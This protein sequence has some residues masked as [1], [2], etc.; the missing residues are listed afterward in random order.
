[1]HGGGGERGAA[2][3]R[4]PGEATREHLLH[5]LGDA[6]LVGCERRRPAAAALHDGPRLDQVPEHLLDEERVAVRVLVDGPDERRRRRVPGVRRDQRADVARAQALEGHPLDQPVAAQVGQQL[7]ERMRRAD[8]RVAERAEDQQR[9]VARCA[10]DVPEQVE[11]AAVGPVQVV[12]HERERGAAGDV[13]QQRRDRLEEQVALQLGIPRAGRGRRRQLGDHPRELPGAGH[14]G[15]PLPVEPGAAQRLHERLV[16]DQHLLLA[17]GVEHGA[18]GLGEVGEL[19]RE[20]RLADARIAGEH[21]HAAAPAARLRPRVAQQPELAIAGHE[22]GAL[23][24]REPAG[25]RDRR[26]LPC[27]L[28]PRALAGEQPLVQRLELRRGRRAELVAQQ[29]PEIVVDPQRLRDVAGARERLHQE[30]VAGLAERRAGDEVAPGPLGVA[31]LGRPEAERRAGDPL[32]RLELEL[33]RLQPAGSPP[34]RRRRPA[35]SRGAGGGARPRRA[36]AWGPTARRARR[37]ARRRGPPRR[38]P[39]RSRPARGAAGAVARAPRA[40][41][42]RA[43]DAGGRGSAAAPP[44][45]RAGPGAA[46]APR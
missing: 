23:A 22:R 44:A 19:A 41:P 9:G 17:R 21:D 10:G 8:L 2:R 15:D 36:R 28:P 11:R 40:R 39:G 3:V 12:E 4:E 45:A 27:D 29:H 38:R 43:R 42:G 34:T 26:R 37:P 30:A 32:E 25:E 31:A 6:D 35:G 1:M 16:G 24:R 46:T 20:A 18:V 7:G 33:L 13:V 5:A 14:R